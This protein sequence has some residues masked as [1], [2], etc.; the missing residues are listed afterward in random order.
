MTTVST[1]N[2]K[3][4][5]FA[6]RCSGSASTNPTIVSELKWE[7]MKDKAIVGNIGHLDN[8]IEMDGPKKG[9]GA[10]RINIKPQYQRWRFQKGTA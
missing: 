4:W 5:P 9:P 10:R 7:R 6:C 3:L 1:V 8:E 2:F